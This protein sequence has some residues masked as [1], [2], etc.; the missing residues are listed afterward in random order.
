MTPPPCDKHKNLQMI[1][2][3]QIFVYVCPVPSCSRQ[4]D[5]QGYFEVVDGQ[6]VRGLTAT[7]RRISSAAEKLAAGGAWFA[8]G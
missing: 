4:H 5:G 6:L 3:R 1:S 7:P 8:T 2:S